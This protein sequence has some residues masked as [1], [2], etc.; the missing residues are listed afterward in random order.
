M[1][2]KNT[3]IILASSSVYRKELLERLGLAFTA[4][5]PNINEEHYQDELIDN[6]VRRLAKTK[7]EYVAKNKNKAKSNYYVSVIINLFYFILT[8]PAI[9][10]MINGM[11]CKFYSIIFFLIYFFSYKIAYEK[12]K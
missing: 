6:Y 2:I 4:I 5:K 3:K 7:A 10:M 9:F 11:F 1:N 8:I 12:V